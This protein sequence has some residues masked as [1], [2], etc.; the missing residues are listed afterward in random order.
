MP[1]AYSAR[2]PH[3]RRWALCVL[4][5]GL[6]LVLA[7]PSVLAQCQTNQNCWPPPGGCAYP[8][9]G[10][11]FYPGTP[12]PMGIR[13]G[14]LSDP[15][16]CAPLPPQGGSQIDSFFDIVVIIELTTDGGTNW[17]PY[18]LPPRPSTVRIQP[19]IPSGPDLF[20]DTEM[21]QL[22]LSGGG[23]PVMIRESPTLPSTGRITQRDLGGGQY[24]LDSFFDVFTELSLDGGQS[25]FPSN[26][27][28]HTTTIDKSP[29][30]TRAST[31]GT[32]KVLYR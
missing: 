30:P 5:A 23:M 18:A 31:W 19:P 29:T 8:A 21:L 9:P 27:P 20:F 32:V 3:H 4:A 2:S 12:G 16:A 14:E 22:D 1:F 7:A 24:Q 11:V 15:S 13:N 28:L 6:A 25:W 17:T 26:Q 10:P